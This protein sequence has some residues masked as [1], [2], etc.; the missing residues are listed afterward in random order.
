MFNTILQAT[1]NFIQHQIREEFVLSTQTMNEQNIITYIDINTKDTLYRVYAIYN[2]EFAQ[3]IS[4]VFLEE[5]ESD[6]ET[7]QDMA[8]ESTN[9]IVGSAKVL[10]Q[11]NDSIAFEIQTPHLQNDDTPLSNVQHTQTISIED[12]QITLTL[13]ELNG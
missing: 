2:S 10:A 3:K 6:E 9:L 7:L 4:F 5:E 13:E 8:L 11:D 12:A 1:Q